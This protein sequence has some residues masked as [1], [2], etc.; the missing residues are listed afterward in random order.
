MESAEHII[1]QPEGSDANLPVPVDA[2]RLTVLAPPATVNLSNYRDIRLEMARTYRLFD[3]KKMGE[4]EAKARHF[5][6]A[7]L[8]QLIKATETDQRLEAVERA[9]GMRRDEERRLAGGGLPAWN[10]RKR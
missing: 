8:A 1:E 9:M 3:Q 10:K 5:M 6:L 2:K 7:S 4:G